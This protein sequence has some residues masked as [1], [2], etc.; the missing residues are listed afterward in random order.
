MSD[1]SYC[2]LGNMYMLKFLCIGLIIFIVYLLSS[3]VTVFPLYSFVMKTLKVISSHSMPIDRFM[4]EI[5]PLLMHGI[6][7]YTKRES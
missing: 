3:F 4:K 7:I 6:Y 2:C 5:L 1:S